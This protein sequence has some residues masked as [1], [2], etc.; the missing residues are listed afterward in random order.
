MKK[1]EYMVNI[2]FKNTDKEDYNR[3]IE[4]TNERIDKYIE[5]NEL[6]ELIHCF[7][8][9]LF[10]IP[11]IIIYTFRYSYHTFGYGACCLPLRRDGIIKSIIINILH[12]FW[13]LLSD[14]LKIFSKEN[15]YRTPLGLIKRLID[16]I[17][18]VSKL[19]VFR[20]RSINEINIRAHNESLET[21]EGWDQGIY[22]A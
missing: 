19:G 15:Y 13:D 10:N 3:D 21:I 2:G 16:D 20:Y 9:R 14:F 12:T 8:Y 5:Q 22:F 4:D 1:I 7:I 6:H 11:S 17:F 18:N